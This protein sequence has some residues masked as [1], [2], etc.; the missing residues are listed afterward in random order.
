MAKELEIQVQQDH[1]ESLTKSNGINALS[2]LIWNSLDAD[3]TEIRI[4]Y[5]KN[6]IGHYNY[7]SIEDNGNGLSYQMAENVFQKLGGSNKKEDKTSPSGRSYHGKE[8]KGR[9]KALALGELVSFESCQQ[10]NENSHN[11][12]NVTISLDNLK[13]PKISD[14]QFV[15]GAKKGFKV[16][17]EN[18]NA[19]TANEIFLNKND[20]REL[21]E[22]FALYYLRYPYFQIFINNQKID[23]DNLIKNQYSE[24]LKIEVGNYFYSFEIKIIEW[25][26]DNKRKTYLCNENG[27]PFLETNFG[28]RSNGIPISIFIQS[29][30]I[31]TLHRQNELNLAELNPTLSNVIEKAKV[32]ARDYVRKR[33]HYYSKEFISE[34][35]TAN[36]YPY[37]EEPKD[38]VET[39]KRQVFDI[40][41]LQINE[42]LP[43]FNEQDDKSKKFIL[44]LVKE[45]LENNTA[46]FQK[47]L[48]EVIGL[49]DDKKEELA[50][51][52]EQT[53][54]ENIIDTMRLV[55]DRL[56]FLNGLEL[57]IYDPEHSINVKERKHLHKIVVNET[58]IFGD[59]YTY[60]ADDLTLKNVLKQYLKYLG[61]E[62]FEEVVDTQD[63]SDLETIPDICLWRQ[64]NL[65]KADC[66]EN[67]IIELKRPT[68]D[69][70]FDE[71]TQIESYATKVSN[72]SRFPKEKTKWTFIL[73]VR[74]IKDELKNSVEQAHRRYGHIMETEYVNVF[75]LRWSDIIQA[76]RAKY[77]Y[78]KDKLDLNF[79]TNENALSLLREK[80][81][82][83]LPEDF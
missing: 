41:A 12:F 54:L 19:K 50:E 30:F 4:N 34:L 3:A 17:I 67:L 5:E 32:I 65:G 2:E 53:S 60:G 37:T 23:F 51:I 22:K 35:K 38:N 26:F 63:N 15:N 1:I 55:T 81:K 49:P 25:N 8:G 14:I 45:A 44:S 79:Q 46:S 82:Q 69:A 31:E 33:L 18:I 75:I 39:A 70:G 29:I 72:D 42:Y 61:R 80:Y 56:D 52:L 20:F 13:K 59:D 16:T 78:I 77:K 64:Y 24:T 57:L 68:K 21:E 28:I 83:Y 76:A 74:D 40:V 10:N 71:K 7:I 6:Q 48:T 66:F 36:L 62:D 43:T 27:I 9:Y 58:W 11:Y 73:L 47:I